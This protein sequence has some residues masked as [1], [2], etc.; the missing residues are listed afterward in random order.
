MKIE[1]LPYKAEH[2]LEIMTGLVELHNNSQEEMEQAAVSN[3][4]NSAAAYTLFIDGEPV[5]AGGMFL[6]HKGV[7]DVWLSVST[8]ATKTPKLVIKTIKEYIEKVMQAAELKRLQT[9]IL[10]DFTTGLRFA[11]AL[12]FQCETPDGMKYY[13]YRGETYKLF[14]LIKEV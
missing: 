5:A 2:G 7:G 14:S 12:G 4:E 11:S 6:R 8:K 1:I 3:E 13:G 9:P 10:A